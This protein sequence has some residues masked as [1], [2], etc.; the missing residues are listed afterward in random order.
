MTFHA[1]LIY[2]GITEQI[3]SGVEAQN[4]GDYDKAIKHYSYV[5]KYAT[6]NDLKE[7]VLMQRGYCW[8]RKGDNYKSINDELEAIKLNPRNDRA[9]F[10]LS[11]A[12]DKLKDTKRA[13]REIEKAIT[14]NPNQKYIEILNR[15]NGD[16][17]LKKGRSLQNNN[18]YKNAISTYTKALSY[19][20][21]NYPIPA[22][23]LYS[24]RAFCQFA[25]GDFK[26]AL[27]D[28]NSS[29]KKYNKN[30]DAYFIRSRINERNGYLSQALDDMIKANNIYPARYSSKY[31]KDIETKISTA[32]RVTAIPNKTSLSLFN[33]LWEVYIEDGNKSGDFGFLAKLLKDPKIIE[34]MIKPR[35][36]SITDKEIEALVNEAGVNIFMEDILNGVFE[37][38]NVSDALSHIK[39]EQ[40]LIN[41]LD[42]RWQY[43]N[44]MFMH[45]I[46]NMMLK[47][48]S[49]RDIYESLTIFLD[50][51]S[52]YKKL[53]SKLLKNHEILSEM[54]IFDKQ[55]ISHKKALDNIFRS[56]NL[57]NTEKE[58]KK[59]LIDMMN[60]RY[61]DYE[62]SKWLLKQVR[63]KENRSAIINFIHKLLGS[64]KTRELWVK[65][66][67][68][69]ITEPKSKNS[70]E[71]TDKIM[72]VPFVKKGIEDLYIYMYTE[73]E[74]LN[75]IKQK[76]EKS[77]LYGPFYNFLQDIY[78]NSFKIA[79]NQ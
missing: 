4:K 13:I 75:I 10:Y 45:S 12:F 41:K 15:Y 76:V 73:E 63:Y 27:N 74:Y 49:V 6:L 67:A 25:I 33:Q 24:N 44:N 34:K 54:Y 64:H 43:T 66:Y 47:S 3:S 26:K 23:V 65:A 69:S 71:Y 68:L 60:K 7:L 70:M 77:F 35:P 37:E 72:S 42:E 56:V 21:I 8:L 1:S 50:F 11:I 28:A 38:P 20:N 36:D 59:A 61:M 2:A 57:K 48:E 53:Y 79:S 52:V 62:E 16:L 30:G 5:L 31:I 14:I 78:I 29:I 18:D 39:R 17:M 46:I 9:L 32:K 22:S 51:S 55:K 40:D 58:L 19:Y